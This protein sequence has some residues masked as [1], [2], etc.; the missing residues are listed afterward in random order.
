MFLR[1]CRKKGARGCAWYVA[2]VSMKTF[3]KKKV[4]KKTTSPHLPSLL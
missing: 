4:F 3:M 1:H 2:E